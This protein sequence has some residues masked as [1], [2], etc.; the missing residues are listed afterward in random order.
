MLGKDSATGSGT[1]SVGMNSRG[2]NQISRKPDP[3][4]ML[5]EKKWGGESTIMNTPI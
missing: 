3:E 2:G 4:E 5:R 1:G